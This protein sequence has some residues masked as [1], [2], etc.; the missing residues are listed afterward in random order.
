MAL[1]RHVVALVGEG[2]M[3]ASARLGETP[4]AI[5]DASIAGDVFGRCIDPKTLDIG[6]N[7]RGL[8][9]VDFEDGT[10][11]FLAAHFLAT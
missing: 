7:A 1:G 3:L 4:F 5:L 2:A 8:L 10:G 9:E 11:G 6:G